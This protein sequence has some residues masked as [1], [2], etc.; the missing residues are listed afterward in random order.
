LGRENFD[1]PL[2]LR[3]GVSYTFLENYTV[4]AEEVKAG[5]SAASSA[6][7]AEA[8][9]RT[10]PKEYFSA[11]AGF[12]TGRSRYAGPGFTAGVG[13]GNRELKVDYAFV[14][15]GDLGDSHRVTVS[16]SFGGKRPERFSRASYYGLPPDRV[17]R[18]PVQNK[19]E[20]KK[21]KKSKDGGVY[22]MW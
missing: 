1:L 2:M 7:G 10:G 9:L 13:L 22:F 4:A 6:I 20:N 17:K 21:E 18:Q 12:K 11:R 8:R 14:P 16:F 3:G 5:G 15:Y 19:K